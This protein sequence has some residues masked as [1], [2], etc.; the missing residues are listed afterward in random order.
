MGDMVTATLSGAF[1]SGPDGLLQLAT[2]GI[3]IN[4][5]FCPLAF[6]QLTNGMQSSQFQTASHLKV[7]LTPTSQS[8]II[9][10]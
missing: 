10:K 8:C 7:L 6:I 1:T 2:P 5:E 4:G 9:D 3:S